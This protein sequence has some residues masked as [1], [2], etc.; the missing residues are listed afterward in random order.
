MSL[1]TM[2][3]VT[4]KVGGW[5]AEGEGEGEGMGEVR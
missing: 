3:L 1:I 5:V 2:S 4:G